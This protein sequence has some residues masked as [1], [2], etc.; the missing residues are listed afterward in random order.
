MDYITFDMNDAPIGIGSV[1]KTDKTVSVPSRVGSVIEVVF[2]EDATML[3]IAGVRGLVE[4]VH[5]T[6]V[7]LTEFERILF[8]A[9]S[10]HKAYLSED[11]THELAQRLTAVMWSCADAD[12]N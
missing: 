12:T 9:M 6:V 11:E 7:D 2:R 4:N 10:E 8:N 5:V 1:V 3:K